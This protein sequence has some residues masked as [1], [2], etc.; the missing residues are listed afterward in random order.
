M[1]LAARSFASDTG[2][3]GVGIRGSIRDKMGFT[4]YSTFSTSPGFL[5]L[6]GD[7]RNWEVFS[8]Y[9]NKEWEKDYITR[10]N[11]TQ[12]EQLPADEWTKADVW[13]AS[14]LEDEFW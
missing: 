9:A 6:I 4:T 12:F 13:D 2:C 7:V 5:L 8:Y 11:F 10:E 14:V 3:C 1:E